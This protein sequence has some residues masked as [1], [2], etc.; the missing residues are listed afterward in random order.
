MICIPSW[1]WEFFTSWIWRLFTPEWLTAIGTVGAVV[2]ALLLALWGQWVGQLL[3]HPVLNLD[4]R[5]QRP[6]ADKVRRYRLD[7]SG[8][9]IADL[10]EYYYFRLAVTNKGRTAAENVQV[11][12][13][14]VELVRDHGLETVSRFTPM[15][16]IWANTE[17][18]PPK[19]RVTRPLL[20]ADTPPVYCDLAHVGQPHK[21]LLQGAEDLENVPAYKAVLGLDVQVPTYSKGHLL[22]PGTYHFSLTLAASNCRSTHYV[23]KVSFPGDWLP[24]VEEMF[25][26]GFKMVSL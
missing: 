19:D 17:Q 4:A 6:D 11:F 14:K 9:P 8:Y 16:L 24:D 26:T 25:K 1:L 22:E 18:M 7:A 21:R 5:V 23:V 13:S 2:V 3:F 20:L 12:L 15:N 10:G